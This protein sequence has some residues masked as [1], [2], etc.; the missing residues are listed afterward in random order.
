MEQEVSY[1]EEEMKIGSVVTDNI[2]Y[3]CNDNQF[4]NNSE[5]GFFAVFNS[6]TEEYN[7]TKKTQDEIA[8][9]MRLSRITVNKHIN[10]LIEKGMLIRRK[11]ND[12]DGNSVTKLYINPN[13]FFRGEDP[14][15]IPLHLILMFAELESKIDILKGLPF[16]FH[17]EIE[18]VYFPE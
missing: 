3:L 4:L 13:I 8:A 15:K 6:I 11:E 18:I 14:E 12:Q 16:K 1:N 5:M 17:E 9:A 7:A 2:A 10:S